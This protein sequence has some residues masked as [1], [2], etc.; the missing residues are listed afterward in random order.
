MQKFAITEHFEVSRE[1]NEVFEGNW[2]L[3]QIVVFICY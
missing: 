1:K 2:N 3:N